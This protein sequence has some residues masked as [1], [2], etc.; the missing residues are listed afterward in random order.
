MDVYCDILE[1]EG[2]PTQALE[3]LTGVLPDMHARAWA[4]DKQQYYPNRAYSPNIQALSQMWLDRVM[5]VFVAYDRTTNQPVGFLMGIVFRPIPYQA[6]VF[7]IE[8]W[9]SDGDKE[10]E[11]TLFKYM[12]DA[13]RFLGCNEIWLSGVQGDTPDIMDSKWKKSNIFIVE[14]YEKA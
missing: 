11:N 8:D 12:K 10:V 9:F 5:K 3:K 2:E 13:L 1:P 6:S 14:R 4:K 7:Q